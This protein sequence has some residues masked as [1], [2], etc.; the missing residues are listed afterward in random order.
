MKAGVAQEIFQVVIACDRTKNF[1]LERNEREILIVRLGM[2]NG[3]DFNEQEFR[4]NFI[5]NISLHDLLGLLRD[6]LNDDVKDSVAK[7]IFQLEP[8]ELIKAVI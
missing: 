8:L 3:V 5:G 4:S 6:L 1:I 2:I 7:R